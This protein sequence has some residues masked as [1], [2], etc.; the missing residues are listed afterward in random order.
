MKEGETGNT[1]RYGREKEEGE[2][3]EMGKQA[4]EEGA[5]GGGEE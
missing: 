3:R 1:W 5:G 4:E 2:G